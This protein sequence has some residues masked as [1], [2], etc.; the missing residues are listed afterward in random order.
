MNRL[1]MGGFG[2]IDGRPDDKKPK[3]NRNKL[4]NRVVF[5]E[6]NPFSAR[7]R[8]EWDDE[9][10]VEN[11]VS[12]EKPPDEVRIKYKPT[13]VVAYFVESNQFPDSKPPNRKRES[14]WLVP[15][16]I[17]GTT[18]FYVSNERFK[19]LFEI[20]EDEGRIIE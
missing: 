17:L 7:D 16:L 9:Y 14:G 4:K 8:G 6:E 5:L 11:F 18:M 13:E 20:I 19:E 12:D 15:D 3:L 10:Q 2:K 1:K